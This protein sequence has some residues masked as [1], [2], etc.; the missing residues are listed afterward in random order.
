MHETRLETGAE[1]PYWRRVTTQI[2]VVLSFGW[3]F[4]STNQKHYPDLG[5]DA[6]SVRNFCTRSLDVSLSLRGKPRNA[7][8]FYICLLDFR[9]L[10][11]H[12]YNLSS[13]L[14]HLNNHNMLRRSSMYYNRHDGWLESNEEVAI[15]T[16][17]TRPSN[18]RRRFCRSEVDTS[19]FNKLR[20]ILERKGSQWD[21]AVGHF[22]VGRVWF[23]SRAEDGEWCSDEHDCCNSCEFK[24]VM[25]IVLAKTYQQGKRGFLTNTAMSRIWQK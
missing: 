4:A 12:L 3:R 1:I 2:W 9:T 18:S 6:S 11:C 21:C 22:Y 23:V 25:F 10:V 17:S 13:R 16:V 15:W 5:S 8:F 24:E 20:D 19:A 14:C 7:S